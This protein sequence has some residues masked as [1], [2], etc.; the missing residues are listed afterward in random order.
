[1]VPLVSEKQL[2]ANR[3]NAHLGGV[4]TDAGK[5]VSSRNATKFGIF[6]KA[7]VLEEVE[8]EGEYRKMRA[9][10]FDELQPVGILEEGLVDRL[11]VLQWRMAR[12]GRAEVAM[13][14]KGRMEAAMKHD[15]EETQHVIFH[16][17][18]PSIDYVEHFRVSLICKSLI[19]SVDNFVTGLEWFGL[20]LSDHFRKELKSRFGSTHDFPQI[21]HILDFDLVAQTKT[22]EMN[23]DAFWEERLK[24]PSLSDSDKKSLEDLTKIA[25]EFA[26]H[27]LELARARLRFW[28]E[29][30]WK[31]DEAEKD[32]K[33]VPPEKDLLALHRGE[34]NLHRMWMQTLHELQR[35][36]SMRLGKPPPL[37]AAIDVNVSGAGNGFDL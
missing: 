32:S 8:D 18:R 10:F 37:A 29:M 30:E 24:D 26:G 27:M 13:I 19:F 21:K 28:E 14:Q 31:R 4:K 1:M 9:R 34:S 3:K 5:T 20:P 36:Q 17:D 35:I 12:I 16:A 11:A 6:S 23:K 7:I 22:K 33:L 2:V 25:R 15:L